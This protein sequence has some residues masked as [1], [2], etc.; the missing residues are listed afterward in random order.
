ME[1][2][3]EKDIICSSITDGFSNC[4]NLQNKSD[5]RTSLIILS[6]AQGA[7]G[8][9]TGLIH[10]AESMGTPVVM[11]SGPTS[12]ETGANVRLSNSSQIYSNVWCRP[13]SKNGA[14]KCIRSERFCMTGITSSE[15]TNSVK[16]MLMSE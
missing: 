11:I 5:L 8:S 3:Y 14:R 2:S 9:D 1:A 10:A 4:I 6:L 7:I 12:R 13:C 16:R 15:V